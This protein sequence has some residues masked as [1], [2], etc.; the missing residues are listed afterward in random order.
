M[1]IIRLRLE[2]KPTSEFRAASVA[3]E[4]VVEAVE[5]VEAQQQGHVG[6]AIDPSEA[7]ALEKKLREGTLTGREKGR[8]MSHRQDRPYKVMRAKAA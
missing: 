4:S 5:I 8:L 1:A 7:L 6:F 2:D 3:A